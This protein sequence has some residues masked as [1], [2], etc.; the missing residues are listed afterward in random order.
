MNR[1]NLIIGA[2]VGVAGVASIGGYAFYRPNIRIKRV[3]F[4]SE[5]D[6]PLTVFDV[7]VTVE[8]TGFSTG[9]AQVIGTVPED[10]EESVQ[11][12]PHRDFVKK[13]DVK[14][15]GG[16]SKTIGF[17][18][19]GIEMGLGAYYRVFQGIFQVRVE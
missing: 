15:D 9:S 4:P 3:K 5:N 18:F 1:R 13:K 2:G 8:N 7:S 17:S 11:F 16:E 6:Y 10:P 12:T 19:D 14:L